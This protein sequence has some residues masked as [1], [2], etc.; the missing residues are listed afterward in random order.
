MKLPEALR[1]AD[2]MELPNARG[3]FITINVSEWG[4][5]KPPCCAIGGANIATRAVTIE[6]ENGQVTNETVSAAQKYYWW[7]TAASSEF[8]S[9]KCPCDSRRDTVPHTVMH[10]Y[11]VHNWSRSRIADWL[12]EYAYEF[13]VDAKVEDEE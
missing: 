4:G 13:L 6:I 2:A 9:M 7:F 8:F 11:D 10:L 5:E 3:H 12:D 1:L